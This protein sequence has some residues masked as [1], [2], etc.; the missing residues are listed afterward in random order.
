MLQGPYFNL[1]D[2]R[3]NH[4]ENSVLYVRSRHGESKLDLDCPHS[5]SDNAGSSQT[6]RLAA[7]CS[8]FTTFVFAFPGPQ[9]LTTLS[10]PS[11]SFLW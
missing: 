9:Y 1:G 5:A 7:V 2:K 4:R 10:W 8:G 11:T 6:L 3:R